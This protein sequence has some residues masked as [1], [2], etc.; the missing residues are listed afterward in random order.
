MLPYADIARTGAGLKVTHHFGLQTTRTGV[1]PDPISFTW[2][3]SENASVAVP[4]S[5]AASSSAYVEASKLLDPGPNANRRISRYFARIF[6]ARYLNAHLGWRKALQ[7]S[8]HVLD[9]AEPIMS[10]EHA[11][12]IFGACVGLMGPAGYAIIADALC[13]C[14]ENPHENDDED[15]NLES[16]QQRPLWEVYWRELVEK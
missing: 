2:R 1:V 13:C 7:Q 6:K 3:P 10:I 12:I 5:D 9:L 16:R 11:R 15:A 8:Q 4:S 14:S